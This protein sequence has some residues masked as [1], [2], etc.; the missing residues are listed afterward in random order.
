MRSL[1]LALCLLAAFA[2]AAPVVV[3]HVQD[4]ETKQPL[5]GVAVMSEGSDI[6]AVTD[7]SG[8]CLVVAVP[9]R[10]GTLVVSRAGYLDARL[11]WPPSAKPARDTVVVDVLLYPNRP[12]V[13]VG[14]VFD[15][16]TKLAIPGARI[17]V[18]GA[19]LSDAAGADGGFAF[20]QFRPGYRPWRCL[21]P[22]IRCSRSPSRF[23]PVRQAALTCT[24]ST[25][26]TSA[27][28]KGR[29]AMP[30]PAFRFEMRGW[31]SREPVAWR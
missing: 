2:V 11:P 15:A 8:R 9:R 25:P 5:P 3:A 6:M 13:V 10:G 21:L 23:R 24:C 14:R 27:A 18:V 20:S 22:A 29:S 17:S 26:P 16:G 30:S 1:I 28:C 4:G 19:E 12:R 7:S 31:Q